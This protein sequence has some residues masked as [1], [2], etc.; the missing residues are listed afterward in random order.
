MNKE[1]REAKDKI[2]AFMEK[3]QNQTVKFRGLD[4]DDKYAYVLT[5]TYLGV[6]DGVHDPLVAL[7]RALTKADICKKDNYIMFTIANPRAKMK[8]F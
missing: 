3:Y 2:L 4:A 7:K 1:L 5:N 6:A 8:L